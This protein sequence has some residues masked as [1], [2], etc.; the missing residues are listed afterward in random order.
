MRR[1]TAQIAEQRFK[2]NQTWIFNVNQGGGGNKKTSR[3]NS[4]ADKAKFKS[5]E[6]IGN[7]VVNKKDNPF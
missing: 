5:K 4:L 6:P 3:K 2:S 7:L 1:I